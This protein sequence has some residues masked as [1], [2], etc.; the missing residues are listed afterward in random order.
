M[1]YSGKLPNRLREI[2][3]GQN[4][5]LDL[6]EKYLDAGRTI[7]ADNFF[8]TIDL[9]RILLTTKT[10]EQNIHSTGVQEEPDGVQPNGYS[11]MLIRA[12]KK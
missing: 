10:A 3:P 1:I 6:V 7:Y 4:V 11:A 8:T 2:N 12:E 9:A 5:V